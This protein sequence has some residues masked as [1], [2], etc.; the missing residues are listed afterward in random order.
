MGHDVPS[1]MENID[2][3]VLMGHLNGTSGGYAQSIQFFVLV[4]MRP[5]MKMSHFSKAWVFSKEYID[6]D[7]SLLE[8]H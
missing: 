2:S 7:F 1:Q 4:P 5:N 3:Q 6:T 8:Y